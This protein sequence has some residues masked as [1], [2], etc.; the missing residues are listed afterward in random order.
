MKILIV[1]NG[2]REHA[3]GW[4]LKQDP[5]VTD[6]VFAPGN[7]GT[8]TLGTNVSIAATDT[9]ALANWA[10]SEK[11][12]LVII[13]PEA[14]LCVGLTDE[15]EQ[16]GI[17]VFGPNKKAAQLEGSKVFTKN[18]LQ[19]AHI[20][21]AQSET[22]AH[23]AE[24]LEYLKSA[25]Y[26]IVVKADGLASGKGVII[27]Q[28]E[29]EAQEAVKKIMI[30][31]DFGAAGTQVLIEEFLDGQEASIHAVTDG[32]ELVVFSP[33]QDHK[34][35]FE[36]DQGPNTGGMGA[37]APTPAVDGPLLEE[38]IGCVFRPLLEEFKKSNIQYKGV[39]Y[40]GLMLTS[41]GPKVLEFNCRFGD[42]ETQVILP[43]L[44]T[45]LLDIILAT[46]SSSLRDIDFRVKNQSAMTVVMASPGYP[47]SPKTGS[48][49]SGLTD[50]CADNQIIFH[51]G[52]SHSEG[53]IKTS[54]GRVLSVT[55]IGNTL[56]N[57]KEV[58]YQGIAK[59]SFESAQF[60]RD[61]GHRAL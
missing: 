21:T 18:L 58:A 34:R 15:I 25:E 12:D 30:D 6:L 59:I 45:P 11:P 39:L 3:I 14:P 41:K 51:A 29:A 36:G 19:R 38:I 40:G 55:G 57:A 22:F 50:V 24:T 27:C 31:Q 20:P 8:T 54:G 1:G 35:I 5:R 9:K 49:I 60:R 13:G 7:A 53:V 10:K 52:T 32:D 56:L 43:L 46:V 2:G 47:E 37:Y 48:P 42:P 4:S 28:S 17:R 33:S 16:L 44:E 23:A 26:P 61:I